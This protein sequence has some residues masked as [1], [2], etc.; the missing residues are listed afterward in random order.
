M[1]ANAHVYV[2]VTAGLHLCGS[3]GPTEM[4]AGRERRDTQAVSALALLL[5]G[6]NFCA[7]GTVPCSPASSPAHQERALKVGV[8]PSPADAATDVRGLSLGLL[9]D[10]IVR[11]RGV[12]LALVYALADQ[13]VRGAQLAIAVNFAYG[14][15]AGMQLAG[16]ANFADEVRGVQ[17][18]LGINVAGRLRGAQLAILNDAA[19]GRG[20]QAGLF[21]KGSRIDGL[22]VGLTNRADEVRGLQVGILNGTGVSEGV[23]IAGVNVTG[24]ASGVDIGLINVTRRARGVQLGVV[25]VTE[26]GEGESLAL[27]NLVKD[28]FH[29]LALYTSDTMLTNLGLKLGDRHLYT[30]LLVAFHPGDD[31]SPAMPQFGRGSRRIGF[32]VGAGWHQ[33][34]AL[35]RIEALEIELAGMGLRA[36]LDESWRDIPVLWSLRVGV[37]VRLSERVGL[38]AGGA[39]NVA[40]ATR[41]RDADVGLGVAEA[42]FRSGSAT[43][44]VYPGLFVGLQL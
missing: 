6:L 27:V 11:L 19:D 42:V 26:R 4:A 8:V 37:V 20:V 13:E 7:A 17:L 33:P 25:N 34:L 1:V 39:A 18:A 22:R 36:R 35:G 31:T 41:E 12:Q 9:G 16:G 44:R 29:A 21:N 3:S 38:L 24:D 43:T 15:L 14:T 10:R 30:A 5:S 40:V 23:Q 28:G 32:G 2:A